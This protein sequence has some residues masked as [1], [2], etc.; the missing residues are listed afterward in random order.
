MRRIASVAFVLL[1][2]PALSS[3]QVSDVIAPNDQL[4]AQGIPPVPRSIADAVG[5]YTE[6][7]A[8]S[9]EDWHPAE[10]TMLIITRFA[11]VPQVH[12]VAAPGGDRR[13]LT[14]FPDRVLAARYAPSDGKTIVIQKDIGGNEFYQLFRYDATSG[15]ATL[16]TDGKSRNEMGPWSTAGTRVA[17]TSTRRNGTDTDI[18][19]IDPTRPASNRLVAQV[20][21]GGWAPLAWSPDD[22]T[23][24]AMQYISINESYL[25]LVDVA[26]GTKTLLTPKTGDPAAYGSAQFSHDGRAIYTTSDDGAEFL[27]L[28]RIDLATHAR[29][30]L[31]P[32]AKWD[33]EAFALSWNGRE[34]ATVSNEDGVSVLRILDATTGAVRLTPRIPI[35]VIHGLAWR[36]GDRDLGFALSS[37]R[38]AQDAYSVDATTG[39]VERWTASETGG[40]DPAQFAEP[41]LVRWK[42]FDGLPLSG[43]LYRPPARFAGRRPVI[44]N[45]HGCPEAQFRPEFLGRVNYYVNVLGVAVLF[46]NVRGSSGYGKTFLKADNGMKR[47]DTYKDID[48]LFDWIA[49]Q[50]DLDADRVMVTGGSYGGHMTL[51]VAT[52][53]PNR[54]RCAVDVVGISNLATFL[55]H[56][57]SY[58][59]D[60]R[61]AEYGDEREPEM[62]AF[63]ERTAPL[64]NA[65]KITKPLFVVQGANDP[66]VPKSEADQMVTAVRGVGTPVWYLVA[67]DEGHGFAKKKNQDFQMYATVAFVQQY[68]LGN[69][70]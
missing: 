42:G 44:I 5:R 28:V 63:M 19:E 6:F 54:I 17:Y 35:G 36:H 27:R 67:T 10:R 2:T 20:D 32:D 47:V 38:S 59:R 50:P 25:W 30:V 26:S 33:V 41:T 21:G 37:A 69:I 46:P 52:N 15:D 39:A 14:F 45:I 60:L 66:R 62:R 48:A 40:L 58:R 8:A 43:F 23:L 7:R 65:S 24:V 22:R 51:A 1:F 29:Q 57:E 12:V 31:T 4:I 61:R 55:E 56:T 34:I 49:T 18:Y 9:F 3:A 11:D 16:L 53:Y 64:N 13:Q 70:Q 68:L